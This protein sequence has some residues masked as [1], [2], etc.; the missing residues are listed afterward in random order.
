MLLIIPEH[1]GKNG[2]GAMAKPRPGHL[3]IPF[4]KK[5]FQSQEEKDR[6]RQGRGAFPWNGAK[7]AH[8]SSFMFVIIS[9]VMV[10]LFHT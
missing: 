9:V 8:S 5:Q 1:T 6:L 10:K 7:S 2:I 4:Y 3:L